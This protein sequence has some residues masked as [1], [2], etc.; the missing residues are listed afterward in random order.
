MATDFFKSMNAKNP[1]YLQEFD[2]PFYTEYS[3]RN[4]KL[5]HS[6][7]ITSITGIYIIE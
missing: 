5:V 2:S 6:V 1:S 4:L 7:N 3:L